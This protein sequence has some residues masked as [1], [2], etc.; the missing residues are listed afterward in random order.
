MSKRN[1]QFYYCEY[2]GERTFYLRRANLTNSASHSMASLS[3]SSAGWSG[4]DT[5][6]VLANRQGLYCS[7]C[8]CSLS[9][10]AMADAPQASGA[11]VL[12]ATNSMGR[13]GRSATSDCRSIISSSSLTTANRI[14]SVLPT[15]HRLPH[16][17]V[18]VPA[19]HVAGGELDVVD[20][21]GTQTR[22]RIH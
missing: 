11:A 22:Q 1:R 15:V 12:L 10:P 9:A 17:P 2:G 18:P 5:A 20:C 21:N 6:S 8:W 16:A 14:W 7:I 13:S 4:A 3:P 19:R